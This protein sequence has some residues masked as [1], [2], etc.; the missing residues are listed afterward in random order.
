MIMYIINRKG[1][2]AKHMSIVSKME[3]IK[4][5][6][7]GTMAREREKKCGQLGM[8]KKR[9][10]FFACGSGVLRLYFCFIF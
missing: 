6:K 7:R 4:D 9:N 8:K 10:H 5:A 2:D 1:N 3:S